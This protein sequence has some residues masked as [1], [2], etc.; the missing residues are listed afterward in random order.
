ME[1][2]KRRGDHLGAGGVPGGGLLKPLARIL[3]RRFLDQDRRAVVHMR[4]GQNFDPPLMWMRDAD[5]QARWYM[6]LKKTWLEAEAQ[7]QEFQNPIE[8]QEL[9]WIN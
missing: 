5:Q 9:S 3:G 1:D 6:Q 4:D 2:H 8:E 7:H